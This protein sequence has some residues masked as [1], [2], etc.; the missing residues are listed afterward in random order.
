MEN[1]YYVFYREKG[2]RYTI[3]VG[4]LGNFFYHH[5]AVYPDM[6]YIRKIIL[7]ILY[8]NYE[9]VIILDSNTGVLLYDSDELPF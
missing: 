3:L 8:K 7:P 6:E 4:I 1:S 9:S 5:T 2:C